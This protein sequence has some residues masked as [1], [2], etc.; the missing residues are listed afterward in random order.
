M[1]TCGHESFV[2]GENAVVFEDQR[3]GGKTGH[4]GSCDADFVRE[5]YQGK[6]SSIALD[7]GFK[8]FLGV[9]PAH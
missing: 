8:L 2:E 7:D 5:S 3:N 1:I 9:L 4:N 6:I